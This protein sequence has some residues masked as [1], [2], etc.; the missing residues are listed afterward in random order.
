[1]KKQ[2]IIKI[3]LIKVYLVFYYVIIFNMTS[4]NIFIEF[5][6]FVN[7]KYIKI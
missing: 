5:F 4:Y 7:I 3:L 2:N 1:M 6:F